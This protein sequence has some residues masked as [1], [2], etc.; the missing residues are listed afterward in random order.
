MAEGH[1][2]APL[3]FVPTLR[4]E[5]CTS[6]LRVSVLPSQS[7]GQVSQ[8]WARLLTFQACCLF[9]ASHRVQGQLCVHTEKAQ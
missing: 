8:A 9:S 4:L 5:G 2:R 6:L 3:K 7:H 1:R